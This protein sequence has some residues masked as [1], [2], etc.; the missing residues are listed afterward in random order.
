MKC[1][2]SILNGVD[3]GDRGSYGT[4]IALNRLSGRN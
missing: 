3:P 2:P 4:F 1:L